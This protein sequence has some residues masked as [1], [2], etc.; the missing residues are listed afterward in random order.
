MKLVQYIW[1]LVSTVDI[2]GLALQHHSIISYSAPMHL[3][4]G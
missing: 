2:D 3:F 1:Y 4:M